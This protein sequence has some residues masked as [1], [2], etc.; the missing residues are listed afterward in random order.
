MPPSMSQF[1]A[2]AV[3]GMDIAEEEPANQGNDGLY[4]RGVSE[5]RDASSI[6]LLPRSWD[7]PTDVNSKQRR[8]GN[9]VSSGLGCIFGRDAAI[10]KALGRSHPE[11]LP[12]Y[13]GLETL[14]QNQAQKRRE[15]LTGLD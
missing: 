2:L 15:L 13:A 5:P 11:D 1:P 10:G 8:T 14:L 9:V 3:M 12:K 6:V 7:E 4:E